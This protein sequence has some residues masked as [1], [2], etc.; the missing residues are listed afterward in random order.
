MEAK[1]GISYSGWEQAFWKAIWE[2]PSQFGFLIWR[3]YFF[4]KNNL[5]LQF[6]CFFNFRTLLSIQLIK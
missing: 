2:L 3:I 6:A 1:F 4:E 5:E